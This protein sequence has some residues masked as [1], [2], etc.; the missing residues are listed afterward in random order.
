MQMLMEIRAETLQEYLNGYKPHYSRI[1]GFRPSG[2][3]F[4]PAEGKTV[5]ANTP[6]GSIPTQQI[7][8]GKGWHTRFGHKDL[9]AQR[10]STKEAMCFGVPY[11]EHSSFRELAMFVMS[12]RIDK[13]VPTVNVGSDAS[14][15]R[16]KAWLDRWTSERNKGGFL[17]PLVEG[18]DEGKEAELWEG[19]SGKGGGAWW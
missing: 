12:L 16:M 7:L 17:K 5:G 19:K 6:P 10:G 4:R 15:Q 3:T 11:S 1:V 9:I 18:E 13:I 2:W 14:R 8:H